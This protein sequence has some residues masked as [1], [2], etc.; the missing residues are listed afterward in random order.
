MSIVIRK[1]SHSDV[2][3]M[4]AIWNEVVREANAFPQEKGFDSNAEAEE[5]FKSQTR[6]A[7]AERDGNVLGLYILHPNNIGRCGSI[8]NASYAVAAKARGMG[9]GRLLV[10]DSLEQGKA[11]GFH[12]LQFN[13]VV[14]TNAGAIRL[15][16][17]LG[18]ERL[19]TIPA[20]YRKND[21]SYEDLLLFFHKL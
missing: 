5:F 17:K 2:P 10:E 1:F 4:R 11:N 21:G 13:A 18:F 20:C 3:E 16:E 7:V 9:I 15:Y 6:S 19:G 8:A 12:V 14:K